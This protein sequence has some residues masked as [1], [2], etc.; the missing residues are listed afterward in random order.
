LPTF[1]SGTLKVAAVNCKG[2][3]AF[4]TSTLY[5]KPGTP[6]VISGAIEGVCAGTVNVAYS[7]SAVNLATGY[8]W[9]PPAN[10][11]IVSG[12]GTTNVIINFGAAF[13]SGTLKVSADNV[14]GSSNLRSLTIRSVPVTP[15]A[16]TGPVAI[17]ANQTGVVYSITPVSTA[18][19][20]NWIVPTGATIIS[21][22][23]S[24]SVTINFGTSGGSVKVR[25]VNACGISSYR[26]LTVAVTCKNSLS[27]APNISL[28]NIFPN[29]SEAQFTLELNDNLNTP[30]TLIISDLAGRII[31]KHSDIENT[32]QLE[33]GLNLPAG[34][35]FAELISGNKRRTIKLIKQE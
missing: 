28:I 8:T 32:T 23:N 2:S 29:P 9:T 13:V 22:Q 18:M 30:A 5:S 21:G 25:A 4:K 3:S 27:Y 35:Y 31:E 6:G 7:I 11:T 14:C 12:Q 19:G 10:A 16:I 34:I 24:T 15:S 17:C 20:Y 1:T 26:T 33:F